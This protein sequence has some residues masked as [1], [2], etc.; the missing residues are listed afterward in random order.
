MYKRKERM[1]V[2]TRQRDRGDKEGAAALEMRTRESA[3][4]RRTLLHLVS[5]EKAGR[6]PRVKES[7]LEKLEK[8]RQK[9]PLLSSQKVICLPAPR[10]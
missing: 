3:A 5:F 7:G 10:C 8:T 9:K 4:W 1:E 2:G 6:E